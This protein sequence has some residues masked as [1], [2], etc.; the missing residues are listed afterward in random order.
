MKD[1]VFFIFILLLGAIIGGGF[2]N[3]KHYIKPDPC[4]Q[5]RT[6]M[7]TVCDSG[8]TEVCL[9]LQAGY[10]NCLRKNKILK[11]NYPKKKEKKSEI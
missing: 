6:E 4:V 9:E 5:Y 8:V 10:F 2:Y 1:F 11:P 7:K 3:L